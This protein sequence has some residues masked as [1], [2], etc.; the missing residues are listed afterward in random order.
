MGW[1]WATGVAE[2][3]EYYKGSG[4][5]QCS[6]L[7]CQVVG[8][9]PKPPSCN[10]QHLDCCPLSEHK[11]CGTDG[12]TLEMAQ[13]AASHFTGRNIQLSSGPLSQADLDAKLSDGKPILMLVGD[14]SPY[15][16]VSVGGCGGGQ[17]YFHDP[18]WEA[19]R[20]DLYTYD[21]LLK[22]SYKWLDTLS[23]A[24]DSSSVVV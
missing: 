12:A 20:Y 6:G 10:G 4:P 8:W 3:T 22:S 2:L 17:Y 7:E 16:V 11:T 21:K 1:C 9:C 5:A 23:E 15:H 24:G 18:E 19:G 14:T 13:Q